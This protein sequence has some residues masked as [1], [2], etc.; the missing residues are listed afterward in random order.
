MAEGYLNLFINDYHK[1]GDNKPHYRAL[2]KIDGVQHEA[3]LW[4]AKDGK[5]GFSGKFKPQ[6]EKTH[7]SNTPATQTIV[8]EAKKVFPGATE[9]GFD[10]P[11][12]F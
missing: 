9:A 1:D 11:V 6:E 5:Q 3:A 4:P 8:E 12:P 2:F 7:Y 10:D